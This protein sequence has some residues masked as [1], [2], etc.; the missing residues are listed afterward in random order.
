MA[1]NH[2]LTLAKQYTLMAE[3]S[4]ICAG[5]KRFES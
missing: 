1:S 4:G 3:R 5:E 2:Y